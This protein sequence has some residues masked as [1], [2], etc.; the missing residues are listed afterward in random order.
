[1]AFM[2]PSD[3]TWI[4]R[5]ISLFPMSKIFLYAFNFLLRFEVRSLI[6]CNLK[7]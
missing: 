7:P 2:N 5:N 1:M 4:N 6:S 3:T